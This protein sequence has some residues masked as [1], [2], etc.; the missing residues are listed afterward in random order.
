MHYIPPSHLHFYLIAFS[1]LAETVLRG[2][3]NENEKP[4]TEATLQIRRFLKIGE[5]RVSAQP[6]CSI[7][8]G[9]HAG[10]IGRR[11]RRQTRIPLAE[12]ELGG[13]PYN[14]S[15]SNQHAFL[16]ISPRR[17][18]RATLMRAI[19]LSPVRRAPWQLR[20]DISALK[21]KSNILSPPSTSNRRTMANGSGTSTAEDTIL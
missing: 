7:G 17:P 18:T 16:S 21:D 2:N 3:L 10:I 1:S 19:F 11:S 8:L 20:A 6:R 5:S 14:I 12:A 9:T 15:I 13:S 4:R